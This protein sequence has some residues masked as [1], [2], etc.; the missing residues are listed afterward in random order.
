V[1]HAKGE[2]KSRTRP[3]VVED[4]AVAEPLVAGELAE[5]EAG[6]VVAAV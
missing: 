3:Q 1:E 6:A 2:A 4:T 5:A